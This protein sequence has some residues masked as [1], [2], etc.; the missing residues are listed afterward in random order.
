MAS[1]QAPLT[2]H[3]AP[4]YRATRPARISSILVIIRLKKF[5]IRIKSLSALLVILKT[6]FREGM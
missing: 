5:L 3:S 2:S 6:G 1:E 4:K